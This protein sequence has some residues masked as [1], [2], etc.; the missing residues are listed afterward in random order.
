M[1]EPVQVVMGGAVD[2]TVVAPQGPLYHDT[3][4]PLREVLRSLTEG[5]RPRI[6][7]DL[8]NVTLCDSSGLNLMAQTQRL[9]TRQGGWLRVARLQPAVRR[10]MEVT[11]LT[12][13]LPIYDSVDAAATQSAT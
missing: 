13:I 10:A 7:L 1:S 2:H 6:V 3:V 12:R 8:S 4:G 9:A 11:N 5:Q